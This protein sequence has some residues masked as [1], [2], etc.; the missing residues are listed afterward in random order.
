[1]QRYDCFLDNGSFLARPGYSVPR[2]RLSSSPRAKSFL[3]VGDLDKYGIDPSR[4]MRWDREPRQ[5]A[6]SQITCTSFGESEVPFLQLEIPA[7]SGG[8]RHQN[9]SE[10]FTWTN[11][12][13][14]LLKSREDAQNHSSRELELRLPRVASRARRY[15]RPS[16]LVLRYRL[17]RCE[18][19]LTER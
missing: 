15:R 17:S 11:C 3:V 7:P 5:D 12:L 13:G 6:R 9:T 14:Y 8:R 2:K 18:G 10:I 16:H 19:R 4:A 1:M